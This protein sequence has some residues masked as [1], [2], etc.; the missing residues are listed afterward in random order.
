MF[1]QFA[2]VLSSHRLAVSSVVAVRSFCR[3]QMRTYLI[4]CDL[5]ASFALT[6][7][8]SP[9]SVRC[10][11]KHEKADTLVAIATLEKQIQDGIVSAGKLSL[12]MFH[13][14]PLWFQSSMFAFCLSGSNTTWWAE[15]TANLRENS[16]SI[17]CTPTTTTAYHTRIGYFTG[18]SCPGAWNIVR[19]SGRRQICAAQVRYHKQWWPAKWEPDSRSDTTGGSLSHLVRYWWLL[20]CFGHSVFLPNHIYC[21]W[22][23]CTWGA[24]PCTLTAIAVWVLYLPWVMNSMQMQMRFDAFVHCGFLYMANTA[25]HPSKYKN[26]TISIKHKAHAHAHLKF[27]HIAHLTSKVESRKPK[28]GGICS[29]ILK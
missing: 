1:R 10:L 15:G 29:C 23:Y 6:A 7:L 24:L 9:D 20:C 12:C 2:N 27:A 5:Q 18:G 11:A 19:N 22:D 28:A 8:G 14:L 4:R 3:R 16:R 13:S 26:Y 21:F 17:A 25:N